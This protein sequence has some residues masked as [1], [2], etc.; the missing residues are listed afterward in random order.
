MIHAPTVLVNDDLFCADLIFK[1]L[2]PRVLPNEGDK[3]VNINDIQS[4]HP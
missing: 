1:K 3:R 4:N 2:L